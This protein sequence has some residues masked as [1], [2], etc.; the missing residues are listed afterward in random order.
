MKDL[1]SLV[2]IGQK[3][4]NLHPI[5]SKSPEV[6]PIHCKSTQVLSSDGHLKD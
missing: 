1:C 3:E 4:K 2:L 5:A 6:I